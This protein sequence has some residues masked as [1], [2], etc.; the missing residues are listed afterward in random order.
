[1]KF[2]GPKSH[3]SYLGNDITNPVGLA[4]L[5]QV[6]DLKGMKGFFCLALEVLRKSLGVLHNGSEG[7]LFAG[8][9]THTITSL[10]RGC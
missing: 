5:E 7:V 8:N 4:S 6:G 10:S 9:G 3:V 2:L 1:M